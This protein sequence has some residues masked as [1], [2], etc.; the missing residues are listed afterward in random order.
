MI[1]PLASVSTNSIGE[2]SKVWQYT[3][4]LPGATIGENCNINAHCFIENDVNIGDNV[5]VKS[6]NYIWDGITIEDNVFLGPNVTL[7]N[8]KKPRSS[9]VDFTPTRTILAKGCTIGGGAV[10]LPGVVVGRFA[11]VGAGSV[12]TKDVPPHALVV[13]NP[14]RI[15]GYVNEDGENILSDKDFYIDL[16]GNRIELKSMNNDF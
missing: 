13:G 5:T 2:S 12:V 9:S 14:A 10:I 8:D 16:E 6:G 15:V 4:I 1:S 3:V 7:T 11:M